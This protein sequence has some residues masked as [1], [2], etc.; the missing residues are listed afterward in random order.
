MIHRTGKQVHHLEHIPETE[1][2][3]KPVV[4]NSELTSD[5]REMESEDLVMM[6]TEGILFAP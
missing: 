1:S 6:D 4:R 2:R 3:V 5:G